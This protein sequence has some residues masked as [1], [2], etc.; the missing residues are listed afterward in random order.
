MNPFQALK[1]VK[2]EPITANALF[3]VSMVEGLK[4]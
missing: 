4:P 3:K 1:G 2:R